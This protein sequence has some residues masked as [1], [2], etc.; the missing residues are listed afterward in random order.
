MT[1]LELFVLLY[2]W[3]DNTFSLKKNNPIKK[4]PK[5]Q[6]REKIKKIFKILKNIKNSFQFDLNMLAKKGM[7]V[8][9]K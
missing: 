4:I 7:L 1:M 2:F 9:Y 5:V 3:K 6:E 8:Y